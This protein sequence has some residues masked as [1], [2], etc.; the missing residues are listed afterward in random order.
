MGKVSEQDQAC[1]KAL[2]WKGA[3]QVGGTE[4][5]QVGVKCQ[6][7]KEGGRQDETLLSQPRQDLA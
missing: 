7:S 2:W 4:R 5:R 6:D 3:Q 1:V